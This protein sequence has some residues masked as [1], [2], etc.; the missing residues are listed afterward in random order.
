VPG[1]VLQERSLPVE[2][3]A[4]VPTPRA[5][6]LQLEEPRSVESTPLASVVILAGTALFG[7]DC[8]TAAS[9]A[10]HRLAPISASPTCENRAPTPCRGLDVMKHERDAFRRAVRRAL[11][12]SPDPRGCGFDPTFSRIAHP[13]ATLTLLT[14]STSRSTE[15]RHLV[16]TGT[17]TCRTSRES[18][19][20]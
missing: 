2:L 12:R 18:L 6:V 3:L 17:R 9:C 16:D 19:R 8:Q 7:S 4:P 20:H 15:D 10:E 5:A 14:R 13:F 1:N 11:T